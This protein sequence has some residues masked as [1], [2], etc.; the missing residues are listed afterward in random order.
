MP[1]RRT[2]SARFKLAVLHSL[3]QFYGAAGPASLLVIWGACVVIGW[4][5]V[6]R[7]SAVI[8]WLLACAVV[9][10]VLGVAIGLVADLQLR[11]LRASHRRLEHQGQSDAQRLARIAGMRFRA[12][13]FGLGAAVLAGGALVAWSMEGLVISGGFIAA[14]LFPTIVLVWRASSLNCS[15]VAG[16]ALFL[17]PVLQKTSTGHDASNA[18][19]HVVH[20]QSALSMAHE[21]GDNGLAAREFLA[22]VRHEDAFWPEIAV[23]LNLSLGAQLKWRAFALIGAMG[24]ALSAAVVAMLLAYFAPVSF[25]LPLAS[26]LDLMSS[27]SPE[28]EQSE[29]PEREMPPQKRDADYEDDGADGGEDDEQGEGVDGDEG[30]EQ[31]EGSDGGE[32][33]EQGEGSDGG[34]VGEQGESVDGDEG[35]E[36]GEQ[37]EGADGGEGG[38]QGV[39]ADGGE[40]GEQGDESEGGEGSGDGT[41]GGDDD[42][43]QDRT[44]APTETE[45]LP[46]SGGE[47]TETQEA[48]VTVQDGVAGREPEER[49]VS[50]GGQGPETDGQE[51]LVLEGQ[52]EA[53]EGDPQ[54]MT[55][56]TLTGGAMGEIPQTE[57]MPFD[58]NPF[59]ARGVGPQSVEV[60]QADIPDFP[61]NLP[62]VDPPTQRVPTWILQLEGVVEQ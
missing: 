20:V 48:R 51:G 19:S 39:G 22:T 46:D 34:E 47:G 9:L 62:E 6:G 45:L 61:D 8:L 24:H 42:T 36:G 38:E 50:I 17:P 27:M 44:Q 18:L 14:A 29:T 1:K 2:C 30:G 60:M 26:P 40:G 53:D 21:S 52:A 59:S 25:F 49:E 15:V 16:V 7:H 58:T 10:V 37:G 12:H 33:G 5:S 4:G 3:R 32:V 35:G 57:T 56:A 41:G 31:G 28:D 43:P 55:A 11:R 54:G 23:T 13:H